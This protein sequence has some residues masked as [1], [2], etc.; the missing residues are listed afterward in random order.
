MVSAVVDM[1]MGVAGM[2]TGRVAA[3][4][5]AEAGLMKAA[6]AV[7]E[8]EDDGDVAV[9]DVDLVDDERKG[10]VVMVEEAVVME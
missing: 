3:L 6:T 2:S 5:V 10:T 7:V 1:N 8:E 9:V 4:M